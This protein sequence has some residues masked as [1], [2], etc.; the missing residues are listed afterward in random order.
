VTNKQFE[1]GPL[2]DELA[3]LS[4][5][6]RSVWKGLA[7]MAGQGKLGALAKELG[8]LVEH[9]EKAGYVPPGKGPE[10]ARFEKS[11]AATSDREHA[12]YY[13]ERAKRARSQTGEK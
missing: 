7:Q 11:A 10:V 8:N 5:N 12:A 9:I 6:A 4:A 13:K 1:T 2:V 3:E